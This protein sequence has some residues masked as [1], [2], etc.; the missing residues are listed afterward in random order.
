MWEVFVLIEVK[1]IFFYFT[2]FFRLLI[3]SI[4]IVLLF[5]NDKLLFYLFLL[6]NYFLS[7]DNSHKLFSTFGYGHEFMAIFERLK[8]VHD[9][10]EKKK[11]Y[12]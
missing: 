5:N 10:L 2:L 6:M 9:Y 4:L 11:V 1:S 12:G 3:G 7:F 8:I